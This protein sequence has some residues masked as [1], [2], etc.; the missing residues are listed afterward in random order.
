[1][2]SLQNWGVSCLSIGVGLW[3]DGN[4]K[5]RKDNSKISVGL[6]N[7]Q[8]FKTT[9]GLVSMFLLAQ[10]GTRYNGFESILQGASLGGPSVPGIE[11]SRMRKLSGFGPN[12]IDGAVFEFP[13][14]AWPG[15]T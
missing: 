2:G 4:A 6:Q 3:G 1:M 5:G 10:T 8:G 11:Y 14:L 9:A 13:R 15:D 12:P 7:R